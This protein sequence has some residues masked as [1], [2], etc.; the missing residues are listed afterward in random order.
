VEE[1]NLFPKR[2]CREVTV[3]VPSLVPIQKCVDVPRQVNAFAH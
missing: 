3:L 1:C 2:H